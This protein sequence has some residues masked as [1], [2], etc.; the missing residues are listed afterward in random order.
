M[1]KMNERHIFCMIR[2]L[3]DNKV[4]RMSAP[5]KMT[6]LTPNNFALRYICNAY[7]KLINRLTLRVYRTR[8]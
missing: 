2:K 5:P 3:A 1:N 8:Y 4:K 6:K 7:F